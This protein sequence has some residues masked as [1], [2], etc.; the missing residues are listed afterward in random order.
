MAAA[1]NK[2]DFSAEELVE[3]DRYATEGGINFEGCLQRRLI[4]PLTRREI[5]GWMPRV[6]IQPV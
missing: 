6:Q 4:R 1:L 3:I 5:V 2:L